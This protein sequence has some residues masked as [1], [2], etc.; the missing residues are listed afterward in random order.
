MRCA[1]SSHPIIRRVHRAFDAISRHHTSPS[2]LSAASAHHLWLRG[3]CG[4]ASRWGALERSPTGV[5][6]EGLAD[7]SQPRVWAGTSVGRIDIVASQNVV[8]LADRTSPARSFLGAWRRH[9]AS[10]DHLCASPLLR[11]D[12]RSDCQVS[13][14]LSS[15]VEEARAAGGSAAADRLRPDSSQRIGENPPA[16][17]PAIFP[18]RRRSCPSEVR[19]FSSS[20]HTVDA[21]SSPG[22]TSSLAA[23][24]VDWVRL[25]H[26]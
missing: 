23:R 24:V 22:G 8:V 17:P 26:A 4:H 16:N 15:E 6:K 7:T 12:S 5:R 2:T 14:R 13:V 19:L 10:F 20:P 18:S 25:I 1:P 11:V 9:A 21:A 3:W